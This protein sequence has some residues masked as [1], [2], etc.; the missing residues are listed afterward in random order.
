MINQHCP[1]DPVFGYCNSEP[2][3]DEQPKRHDV[4]DKDGNDAGFW[5]TGGHCKRDKTSCGFFT[6]HVEIK[7]LE[8]IRSGVSTKDGVVET[9]K[10]AK[11][12]V[13]PT[14]GTFF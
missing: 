6:N 9:K 12:K 14:Q 13:T 1:Q 3:F 11:K 10:K 4:L 7:G 2:D 5:L 8:L